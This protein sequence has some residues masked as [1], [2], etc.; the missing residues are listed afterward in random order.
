M[1]RIRISKTLGIDKERDIVTIF[2]AGGFTDSL[3]QA[4]KTGTLERIILGK[5]EAKK[6]KKVM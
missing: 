2:H 3:E 4:E 5:N 1:T 6:L